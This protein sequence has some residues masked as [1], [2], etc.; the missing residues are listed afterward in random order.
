M[1]LLFI[2]LGTNF[3]DCKEEKAAGS[4][5]GNVMKD[6]LWNPNYTEPF[7]ALQAV[8]GTS[9][10]VHRLSDSYSSLPFSFI[11]K[12][13]TQLCPQRDA[14]DFLS[15]ICLFLTIAICKRQRKKWAL[16]KG[17]NMRNENPFTKCPEFIVKRLEFFK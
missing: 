11:L 4:V 13:I 8:Y 3:N 9:W 10:A 5:L 16:K 15:C 7:W 14:L 2:L 12:D 1:C 6:C 17:F